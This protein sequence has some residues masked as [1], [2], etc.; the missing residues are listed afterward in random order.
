MWVTEYG[1]VIN[2]SAVQ[3]ENAPQPME[4]TECGIVNVSNPEQLLKALFG[5][6]VMESGKVIDVS[7]LHEEKALQSMVLTVFGIV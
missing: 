4:V 7:S 2:F 3:S 6:S 1:M 5:I